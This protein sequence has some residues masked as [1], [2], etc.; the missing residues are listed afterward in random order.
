MKREDVIS[1]LN[2]Y[3]TV[4]SLLGRCTDDFL[5]ILDFTKDEFLIS[6]SAVDVFLM[7]KSQFENAGAVL[8]RTVYPEDYP[9]LQKDLE[10]LKVGKSKVHNLEYRWLGKDG[11]PIWISCRGQVVSDDE[12]N[13]ICLIGRISEIARKSKVDGVTG[14]YRENALLKKLQESAW[15]ETKKGFLLQIGIDNFK[16]INE[17]YGMSV[18][19][20]ILAETGRIILDTVDKKGKVY[21]LDG[22]EMVV[23]MLGEHHE[24]EEPAKELYKEIRRRIDDNISQNGNHIYYT[25]SAG[26]CYFELGEE[27]PDK[28]V[29]QAGFALHQA[30]L[31]GKNTCVKYTQ[32]V[33]NEYVHTLEVQEALREDIE[34]DFRGF[35]LYYQPVVDISRKQI[36]GAEA[37]LRWNSRKFGFMSPG[38][39]IPMLEESG[40]II[41]LGRWIAKTALI[42]CQKWQEKV[43]GFRINVNLSFVQL[44]KSDVLGDILQLM[45]ELHIERSHV[46]FEVTESGELESNAA[47]QVLRSFKQE[48]IHLAIDDF[49]TG[50]SNLRYV[51]NMTFDLVKIDQSFIR[52]ITESQYDYLV[53]KQF[54]ELAHALNLTV[55]YEGVE[56]KE[57]FDC[58]LEL[59]PDYIQGFYFSKPL[60]AQEFEENCL[61]KTLDIA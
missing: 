16:E 20:D 47:C 55:C 33:Y 8:E 22:D 30:K 45:E 3:S 25:I 57:D 12:G 53:V 31:N 56:T 9:L 2:N 49:G 14:L 60:P 51:K 36:L 11:K 29:E 48:S 26:S 5:Y 38:Q 23:L 34:A 59:N 24:E 41:P 6:N 32:Q 39:F 1:K 21:R 42:Q 46:M 37:L 54:T 4:L 50:Y 61:N 27:S 43:P 58:V 18:G 10:M 19:N 28:L 13:A 40:L 15:E 35:E 7:E 44:K 17:R 52:N